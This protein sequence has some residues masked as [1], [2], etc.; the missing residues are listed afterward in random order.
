MIS[1]H[2][3]A[4]EMCL[5]SVAALKSPPKLNHKL[6]LCYNLVARDRCLEILDSTCTMLIIY[7]FS[8]KRYEF[9]LGDP[10]LLEQP[11]RLSDI[12]DYLL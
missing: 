9:V 5:G 12:S 4:S 2:H 8:N 1:A 11:T 3:V 10:S 7:A 6:R